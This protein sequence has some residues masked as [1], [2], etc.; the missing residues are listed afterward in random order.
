MPHAS[1]IASVAFE[2]HRLPELCTFVSRRTLQRLPEPCHLMTSDIAWQLPG[3]DSKSNVRLWYAGDELIGFG[4]FQPP[5][6]LSFDVNA[7]QTA[8]VTLE[9]LRWAVERRQQFAIGTLPY[10]YVRDMEEWAEVGS[11]PAKYQRDEGRILVTSAF[12]GDQETITALEDFGFEATDHTNPHLLHDLDL[13]EPI[14]TGFDVRAIHDDELERYCAA[15]RDAWSPGSTFDT[16]RLKAVM[17]VG[18]IFDGDLCLVA[19]VEGQ[20]AATTIFWV[21]PVAR[22]GSIEPFGVR[23]RYRGRGI[24]KSFILEGL[25]RI[26]RKGMRFGRVYTAGFNH[27]AQRLYQSAGFRV[28]GIARSYKK[29]C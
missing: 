26:E 21:D 10:L 9:I 18:G 28:V 4:W 22:V 1:S 13:P 16:D 27:P 19:E 12:E 24:S 7:G 14:R 25:R 6:S 3:S 17:S 29:A 8:P 2:R 15:H 20:L 23:P 11:H 5:C